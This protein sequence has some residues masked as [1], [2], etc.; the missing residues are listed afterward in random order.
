MNRE[1]SAPKTSTAVAF[2]T[3]A[4]LNAK[5]RDGKVPSN[6][7]RRVSSVVT[8]VATL[9]FGSITALMTAMM[10]QAPA[11]R[12]SLLGLLGAGAFI[13]FLAATTGAFGFLTWRWARSL[14]PSKNLA[15]TQQERDEIGGG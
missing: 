15:I 4:T 5:V 11:G 12:L 13:L 6:I 3:H 9:G 10:L 2:P 1:T 7:G 14:P 8:G